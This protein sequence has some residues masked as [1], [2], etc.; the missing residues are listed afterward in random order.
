MI[1]MRMGVSALWRS[2]SRDMIRSAKRFRQFILASTPL[3]TW[4]HAHFSERQAQVPGCT[5][6]LVSRNGP[7][8]VYLRG[9]AVSADGY[10]CTVTSFDERP[11][12]PP[13]V[14]GTVHC[15]ASDCAANCREG[16]VVT[17]S[18]DGLWDNNSGSSGLS[19]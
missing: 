5:Q 7:G 10:D 11:M 15:P 16:T 19:P 18:S 9:A 13:R 12:T 17:G 3:R 1:A 6:N 4:S 8:T 14:M 2:R